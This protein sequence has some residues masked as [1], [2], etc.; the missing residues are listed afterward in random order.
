MPLPCRHARLPTPH[1]RAHIRVPIQSNHALLEMS[2]SQTTSR[3]RTIHPLPE[4][5]QQSHTWVHA[6][7]L[8]CACVRTQLAVVDDIKQLP[9]SGAH[10][11]IHRA[12]ALGWAGTVRG[13]TQH[14]VTVSPLCHRITHC[15][16][17]RQLIRHFISC[18]TDIFL[19]NE[20]AHVGLS[21]GEGQKSGR[22]R[23][24]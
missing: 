2:L 12:S 8:I 24:R 18:T 7:V 15:T 10:V 3:A 20:C 5:I 16:G 17:A 13:S 11:E 4:V 21:K 6:C 14:C 9:V 1:N 22:L 23:C 19:R